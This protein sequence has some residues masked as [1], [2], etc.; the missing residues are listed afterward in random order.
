MTLDD[1]VE[2]LEKAPQDLRVRDGF[3]SPHSYR[4]SHYCLAVEPAENV[5]VSDMLAELRA[6]RGSRQPGYK[7]GEYLMHGGVEVFLANYG[8]MWQEIGRDM[9]R[10]MLERPAEGAV[11]DLQ[12]RIDDLT[13]LLLRV[14]TGLEALHCTL[15]VQEID[16]VVGVAHK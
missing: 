10:Y 6:V 9:V 7:G 16:R 3:D 5:L 2:A 12:Q 11:D 15:L 14:R 4:G 1:L 8:C 13:A